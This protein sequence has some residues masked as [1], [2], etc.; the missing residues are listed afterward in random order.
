MLNMKVAQVGRHFMKHYPVCLKLKQIIYLVMLEQNII[1][2]IVA[3]IMVIFLMMDL[4]L[5]G[6]DS[7][8][9]EFALY[10]SQKI[11]LK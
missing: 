2:K 3:H 6:K 10:L 11:E 5:L 9:M 7:V 8:I 1:A 4:I